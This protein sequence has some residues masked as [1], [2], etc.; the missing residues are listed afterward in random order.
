MT[1]D[2][3][4]NDDSFVVVFIVSV[5]VFHCHVLSFFVVVCCHVPLFSLMLSFRDVAS[6]VGSY[7][8]LRVTMWRFIMRSL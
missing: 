2:D 5:I 4:D 6:T 1:I 3:Y 7:L 8:P